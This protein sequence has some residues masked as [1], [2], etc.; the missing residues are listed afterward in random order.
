MEW[1]LYPLLMENSP[2]FKLFKFDREAC[3]LGS[4]IPIPG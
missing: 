1:K 3:V 2:I 4:H